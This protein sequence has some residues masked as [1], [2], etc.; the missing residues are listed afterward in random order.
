M[1]SRTCR[2]R[3][4]RFSPCA[5]RAWLSGGDVLAHS[6]DFDGEVVVGGG[7]E[8]SDGDDACEGVCVV[9]VVDDGDVSDF[10]V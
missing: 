9:G 1:C 6:F 5:Q 10:A 8:V 2:A 4:L 3:R 7:V